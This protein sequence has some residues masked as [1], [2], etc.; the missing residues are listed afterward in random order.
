[1]S[2]LKL[3]GQGLTWTVMA[4]VVGALAQGPG[5]AP[6]A[7]GQALLRVSI[8]HLS[9]RL[10]PCRRLTEAERAELPPTRRVRE[11]CERG[12]APTRLTLTVDGRTFLE[13]TIEPAGMSDD[14]RSYL[15]KAFRVD[16]GRY[17]IEIELHDSPE[18]GGPDHQA[19]FDAHLEAGRVALIEI[20]DGGIALD[21]LEARETP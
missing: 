16:P 2:A 10:Q 20:S 18:P 21:L 15:M 6:H 13:E 9:E 4:A 12:R 14:G 11:V 17:V 19:R 3:A 1:M 7:P 5:F 8:A